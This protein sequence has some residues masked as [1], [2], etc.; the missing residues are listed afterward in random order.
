M[1]LEK[2][3]EMWAAKNMPR[4]A[5]FREGRELYER[6]CQDRLASAQKD[7]SDLV[8]SDFAVAA[9]DERLKQSESLYLKA[10]ELCRQ[11]DA[12]HDIAVS[13]YQLG[14]LCHLQGRLHESEAFCTEALEIADS[15]PRLTES[16][17]QLISSC[18]YHLGIL[19]AR[20]GET[21]MATEFLERSFRLDESVSDLQGIHLTRKALARFVADTV[22]DGEE[23]HGA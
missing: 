16:E 17:V 12:Y 23:T 13:C 2:L 15:L 11:E 21:A 4:F 8:E 19:A 22:S 7:F 20:K 18:C 9:S 3:G 1:G 5:L 14:L 6:Y 10:L